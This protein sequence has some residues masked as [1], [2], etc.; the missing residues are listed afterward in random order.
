MRTT[1]RHPP[2]NQGV[3]CW[4]LPIILRRL[5]TW[6]FLRGVIT[7]PGDSTGEPMQLVT[8]YLCIV[9]PGGGTLPPH[10]CLPNIRPDSSLPTALRFGICRTRLCYPPTLLWWPCPLWHYPPPPHPP[11]GPHGDFYPRGPSSWWSL[12]KSPWPCGRPRSLWEQCGKRQGVYQVSNSYW[13]H[14]TLCG[15]YWHKPVSYCSRGCG[16][17]A[18]QL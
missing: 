11:P 12:F 17:P 16:I 14:H 4:S 15:Q 6:D 2:L 3:P 7:C 18:D 9:H 8:H 10:Y 13:V 1:W 5:C